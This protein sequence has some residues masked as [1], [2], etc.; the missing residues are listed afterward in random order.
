M[1]SVHPSMRFKTAISEALAAAEA[2]RDAECARFE[3]NRSRWKY[4]TTKRVLRKARFDQ[5]SAAFD[6]VIEA[7][8]EAAKTLT[9]R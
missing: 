7:M 8:R 3:R 5:R 9:L 6:T 1:Q 4:R 2:Y